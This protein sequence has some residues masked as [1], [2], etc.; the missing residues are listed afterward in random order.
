MKRGTALAMALATP[1]IM[2]LVA[3]CISQKSNV[4][5]VTSVDK[6]PS[7]TMA[8][9]SQENSE[10]DILK[11]VTKPA[12]A[13]KK[14][15]PKPTP[16]PAPLRLAPVTKRG[17]TETNAPGPA[18]KPTRSKRNRWGNPFIQHVYKA[19][20]T[21]PD[22]PL[23]TFFARDYRTRIFLNEANNFLESRGMEYS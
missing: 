2:F 1:I 8:V 23:S 6:D 12:P 16:K 17:G 7:Q 10:P 5:T 20:S 21:R 4:S 15:V 13:M 18:P 22:K 3:G 14:V 11:T 19:Q 9:D